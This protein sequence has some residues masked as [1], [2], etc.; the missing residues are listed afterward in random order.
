MDTVAIGGGGGGGFHIYDNYSQQYIVF[1]L[2]SEIK[3]QINQL[4]NLPEGL[5]M[6][7]RTYMVK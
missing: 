1:L 4:I 2:F 3:I 7:S 6:I 5:S